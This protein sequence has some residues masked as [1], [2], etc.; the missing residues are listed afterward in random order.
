M[1]LIVKKTTKEQ[2]ITL[3]K[4]YDSWCNY[5]EVKDL[6]PI[7]AEGYIKNMLVFVPM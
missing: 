7:Q 3:C 2:W 4:K 5:E 1:K 6:T